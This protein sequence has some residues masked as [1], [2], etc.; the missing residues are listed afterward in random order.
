MLRRP[1]T[2]I[3]YILTERSYLGEEF[4]CGGGSSSSIGDGDDECKKKLLGKLLLVSNYSGLCC[5][6]DEERP[7]REK[8]PE[9]I[10]L[11]QYFMSN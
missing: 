6:W 2:T 9:S 11:K 4:L 3:D 10:P 5:C 7:T 8:S 1:P